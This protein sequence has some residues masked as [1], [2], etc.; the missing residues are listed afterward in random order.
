M[1]SEWRET[2]LGELCEVNPDRMGPSWRYDPMEYIEISSV[3]VG[4]LLEP[5]VSIAVADAPSRAQRL[6]RAG[7]TIVSSVRP[8]RRSFLYMRDPKPNT[9][10]STGFAVL[11]ARAGLDARFLYY[12]ATTQ[13]FT[14]YLVFREEGAAYPSVTPD[15]FEDAPV[16]VPPLPVQRSI[17]RVLGALDDK[18]ELNRRMNGTLEQMC[19]A[20]FKSW[21]IDF[22]PVKRNMARRSGQRQP[23][24]PPLLPAGEGR[25]HYRGGFDY[26]GL[27]ERA[28]ELRSKQTA[29]EAILWEL[30]RNRRLAGLK[31]RRQH[32]LGDY[33]IDFYC[34]EARLAIELD[35]PVHDS[36]GRRQH[37]AKRDAYLE[38]LGVTVKRFR[39]EEVSEDPEG[40]LAE[41]A[42]AG[43]STF[44]RGGGEGGVSDIDALFP[45]ALVESPLGKI[46]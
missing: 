31:F 6:V 38:S 43:S 13:A 41:I 36:P 46:P 16:R 11:R 28:R 9:V 2:T 5:P 18:I 8:N 22:D 30:L 26:S 39:N 27:V 20:I 17:A 14:D 44:G 3:G 19:R 21:F 24:S 4:Q 34:A 40:V 37:D 12:L 35:G 25:G 23:S 42:S 45:D 7:D 15:V 33:V 10:V 32:Q 1:P 29:A